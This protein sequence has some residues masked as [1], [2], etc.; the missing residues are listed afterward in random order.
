MIEIRH[1]LEETR[2]EPSLGL[3]WEPNPSPGSVA[4][5]KKCLQGCNFSASVP[6]ACLERSGLGTT[7]S[8]RPSAIDI[9]LHDPP[10][11][12][13]V[14]GLTTPLQVTDAQCHRHPPFGR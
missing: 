6:L 4:V 3:S 12:C 14:V 8:E 10:S 11:Y 1:E 5:M 2:A 7:A 9:H 13:T